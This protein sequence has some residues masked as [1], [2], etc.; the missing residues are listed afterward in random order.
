[1]CSKNGLIQPFTNMKKIIPILFVL[2][3]ATIPLE[4]VLALDVTWAV[5][6]S[7]D[8]DIRDAVEVL[9][10]AD[11]PTEETTIYAV[12]DVTE[13]STVTWL[14]SVIA[15]VGVDPPYE[16]WNLMENGVWMD[17]VEVT[18]SDPTYSAEYY[19]PELGAMGGGTALVFPWRPGT[20][21]Q[22]GYRGVHDAGFDT[23]LIANDFVGG[24]HMAADVMPP[25][26]YAAADGEIFWVC[27]DAYSV[28]IKVLSSQG[29]FVYAHLKDNANLV[30]GGRVYQARQIASL[31]YGSFNGTCGWASQTNT[32]YHL[33]FGFSPAC[34]R[35]GGCVLNTDTGAWTCGD[36]T[37]NVNGWLKEETGSVP[38]DDGSD[39]GVPDLT[40]GSFWDGP[41]NAV[42][43]I[44]GT[45]MAF[46]W[47]ANPEVSMSSEA[48]DGFRQMILNEL[49]FAN[50]LLPFL[51]SFSPILLVG[52]FL[53]IA[54]LV[55][56]LYAIWEIFLKL[57]PLA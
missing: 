27:K 39:D 52:T 46:I 57:L 24:D 44:V 30:Q 20:R 10:E 38:P 48:F 3:I 36:K 37:I 17:T 23:N 28:T 51:I 16:E 5:G 19:V 40:G 18:F 1:M 54:E 15:L 35:I 49:S 6:V 14:I 43:T 22:Y 56:V 45:T 42:N 11:P 47:G 26:A 7:I 2:I 32:N 50:V 4:S 25:Y 8:T 9:L 21:A 34:N 31:V 55:R 12:T 53:A 33:H 41:L 29:G 13:T